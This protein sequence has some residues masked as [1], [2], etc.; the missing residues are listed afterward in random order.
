[1]VPGAYVPPGTSR[2]VPRPGYGILSQKAVLRQ[3]GD[4]YP[5]GEPAL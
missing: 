3:S 1:M 4:G 5:E 2:L